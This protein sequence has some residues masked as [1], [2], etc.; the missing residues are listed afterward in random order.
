[1]AKGNFGE[2]RSRTS[3]PA[4]TASESAARPDLQQQYPTVRPHP[5]LTDDKIPGSIHEM[6]RRYF[7]WPSL[8][9]GCG[10]TAR[11]E[12]AE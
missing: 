10:G 3:V 1:M 12:Q 11:L 2:G 8:L 5:L 4:G 7:G 9:R 6:Y